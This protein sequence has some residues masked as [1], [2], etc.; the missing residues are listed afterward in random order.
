MRNGMRSLAVEAQL[1]GIDMEWKIH[2]SR[3]VVRNPPSA[4]SL[5][6]TVDVLRYDR[7]RSVEPETP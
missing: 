5:R 7:T 6:A 2:P 4:R 1:H 3:L